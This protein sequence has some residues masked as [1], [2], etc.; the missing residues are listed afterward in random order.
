MTYL[1]HYPELQNLL[2]VGTLGK[3]L[4]QVNSDCCCTLLP[5]VELYNIV[6]VIT[7]RITIIYVMNIQR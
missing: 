2:M 7:S 3:T 5:D 1:R 4:S 6:I